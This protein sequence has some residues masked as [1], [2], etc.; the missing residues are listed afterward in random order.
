MFE[1]RLIACFLIAENE[2]SRPALSGRPAQSWAWAGPSCLV[3]A[4]VSSLVLVTFIPP[5]LPKMLMN[6]RTVCFCQPV[7][8]TMPSS[9]APHFR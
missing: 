5:L 9:V 4:R 6:P 1:R 2:R 7:V 3:N 8:L